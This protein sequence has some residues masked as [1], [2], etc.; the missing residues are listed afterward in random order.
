[1][2]GFSAEL[3]RRRLAA[4]LAAAF[5]P[6][7]GVLAQE[8]VD[9]TD[10]T[11]RLDTAHRLTVRASINGS[12]PF[13]FMV[14]TGANASVISSDLADSLKLPR[15]KPVSLHGIAG[16]EL[17][18]TVNVESV[19]VGRRT[20][21]NMTLSVLPARFIRAPGIL[22]LDW[23]GSQGVLLDF[24]RNQMK[25]GSRPPM[26]DEYTISVPVRSRP[27]GLHLIDVTVSGAPVLAFVDTGSTTTVGNAALMEQAIRRG[28]LSSDWADIQLV[29]LTGQTMLGR[30]ATLK[31]LGIDKITLQNLP[32]VFGPIHTFEYWGLVNRPAILIG[33]DVLKVFDKVALDF[34]R[35]Q[36]HFTISPSSTG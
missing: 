3:S 19:T 23:L 25:I 35:G 14:D 6:A 15:G 11:R 5:T 18:D 16:V 10:P 4:F 21:R 13:P 36:M 2:P 34:T 33:M 31:S 29:S 17:V 28:A 32:V 26:T 22:G 8:L 9:P 30:I 24:E 20:R 12:D 27:S 1:M 7:T